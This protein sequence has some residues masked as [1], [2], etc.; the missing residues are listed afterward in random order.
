MGLQRLAER[1]K[2]VFCICTH[3]PVC[4]QSAKTGETLVFVD[5]REGGN[6]RLETH[7][8]RKKNKETRDGLQNSGREVISSKNTFCYDGKEGGNDVQKKGKI[9]NL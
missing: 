3:C 8:N 9:R 1:V 2:C 4:L 6:E 5:C 7:R